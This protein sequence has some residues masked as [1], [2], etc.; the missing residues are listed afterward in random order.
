MNAQEQ[1]TA[2]RRALT[3]ATHCRE[4]FNTL[5]PNSADFRLGKLALSELENSAEFLIEAIHANFIIK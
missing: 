4:L 5:P 3:A 1:I 2:F